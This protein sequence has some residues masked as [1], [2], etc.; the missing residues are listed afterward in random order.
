ML[1]VKLRRAEFPN[2]FY[3]LL[4][5]TN[6]T[7][8]RAQIIYSYKWRDKHFHTFSIV[9]YSVSSCEW[10]VMCSRFYFFFSVSLPCTEMLFAYIFLIILFLIFL[11]THLFF[12]LLLLGVVDSF[13]AWVHIFS[14]VLFLSNVY[15]EY[16][17]FL[18][19][20]ISWSIASLNRCGDNRY[21][22]YLMA[23]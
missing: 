4:V 12:F 23:E 11:L 5:C 7:C 9:S 13:V 17:F 1:L 15:I 19:E 18:G 22:T 2:I 20:C 8:I 3:F 6:N 16:I 21:F 10:C 14:F